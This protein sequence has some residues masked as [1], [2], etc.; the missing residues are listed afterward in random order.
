MS[1]SHSPF[2]RSETTNFNILP[3]IH[4]HYKFP[5][6]RL[7]SQS[8][9]KTA[10]KRMWSCMLLL[11]NQ[12]TQQVNSSFQNSKLFY[13]YDR[14]LRTKNVHYYIWGILY[15]YYLKILKAPAKIFFKSLR[16]YYASVKSLEFGQQILKEKTFLP[17]PKAKKTFD[18][19]KQAKTSIYFSQ[20]QQ[21]HHKHVCE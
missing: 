5:G 4:T 12:N 1:K 18:N 16:K 7:R 20:Q 6:K 3:L 15:T 10:T 11:V 17:C 21:Q 19:D 13:H 9:K 14:I 8:W 2:F